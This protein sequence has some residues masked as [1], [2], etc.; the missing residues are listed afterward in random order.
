MAIS[1]TEFGD[2]ISRKSRA[3]EE[4]LSLYKILHE[5]R[6][7]IRV[8]GLF[9]PLIPLDEE[10]HLDEDEKE[11]ARAQPPHWAG[12]APDCEATPPSV[13]HS[14]LQT[15]VRDQKDRGT[16]VCFASLACLEA[17][18]KN[19]EN[20]EVDLSEQFANRLFMKFSGKDQ[21]ADGLKTTLAAKYLSERGVCKEDLDPYEDLQAVTRHCSDQP[22][23]AAQDGAVYGIGDYSLIDG[24]GLLGP[25]INNTDYLECLLSGGHDIVFGTHVAWGL[26][27]ANGVH[28]VKL[29][30][31]GNPL[32][33]RG[34]HAMLIV[35]YER[36]VQTPYFIVKNSWGPDFAHRGYMHLSYDYVRQYGK[37]GY[38]VHQFRTDIPVVEV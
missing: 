19:A 14:E 12:N 20:L 33:S 17:L 18:A 32:A 11:V 22:S 34:G 1:M 3:T 6:N 30:T 38:I 15:P 28:D 21:C 27:D 16:C 25:S 2:S 5:N 24:L 4:D 23:Q 31:F 26:P 37:Y 35:G 13:D 8:D 10:D 29:D 36:N 7:A 9:V